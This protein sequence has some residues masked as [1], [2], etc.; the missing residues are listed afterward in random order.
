M[1]DPLA[2]E[3]LRPPTPGQLRRLLS[4]ERLRPRRSLSQNFLTDPAAL[5]AIVAAAE[6]R[7]GDRV[8]EVGP[9]LGV[10]TRRLLAAGALVLAVELDPRL[11]GW[12]R[13]ELGAVA[14]FELVEAD[15][16]EID[17][18]TCFPGEP[19]K[20]VANIPYHITS[21]L[22]HAF[23]EGERPPQLTVL[24]VQLEVAERIAAP[25]GQMSYLSV[26]VQNV[27]SAEV[28]ARVPAEAFEPAPK[29]D[30]AVLRLGRRPDP[31]IPPGEGREPFYRIVQAGFRQRRKQLHNGL[32]RELPLPAGA[33]D[34]ALAAC[35]IDPQR[36]PQTL[37]VDEWACLAR[38]L[39]PVLEADR[40]GRRQTEPPA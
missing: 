7:P 14:G 35:G 6:L 36:R 24:L 25:P 19:Y 8:V 10:L 2:P 9:G 17:P 22:L 13:R 20:V 11:A 29:V 23:L 33:L 15:A 4:S 40:R 18:S 3:R 39:A 31:P 37:S 21:P 28:V 38:H 32:G 30:S 27:A 34:R 12:L 16:L 26:F 5:D 1:T